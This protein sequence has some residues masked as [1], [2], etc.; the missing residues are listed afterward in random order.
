MFIVNYKVRK[1]HNICI[2]NH[3]V[4]STF[5]TACLVCLSIVGMLDI[6]LISWRKSTGCHIINDFFS[7]SVEAIFAFKSV[8]VVISTMKIIFPF[9]HQCQ[10]LKKTFLLCSFIWLTFFILYSVSIVVASVRYNNIFFDKFCSVGECHIPK[11]RRLMYAFTCSADC[12]FLL[13]IFIILLKPTFILREK[14]QTAI[15]SR[16]LIVSR[17]IFRLTKKVIPQTTF[18]FC[19]YM[20]PLVQLIDTSWKEQYCYAV[21]S[22][23]LPIII[24]IDCILS[25]Y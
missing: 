7:I 12:V 8:A 18:T 15:I 16:T 25:I 2:P 20:I 4:A 10:W 11:N 6:H 21:F 23:V 1:Y 3:L 13:T 9:A 24:V 19:L 5:T 14:N 22:Y 17:V